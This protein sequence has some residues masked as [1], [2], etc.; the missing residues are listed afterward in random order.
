[1]KFFLVTILPAGAAAAYPCSPIYSIDPR[2]RLLSATTAATTMTW[3]YILLALAL[4]ATAFAQSIQIL[5]PIHDQTV[6]DEFQVEIELLVS[7]STFVSFHGT[8]ST[9]HPTS[10]LHLPAGQ[11]WA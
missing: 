10:S 8:L 1:L 2:C 5:S 11:Q 3:R 6:G 9:E 4:F 7:H